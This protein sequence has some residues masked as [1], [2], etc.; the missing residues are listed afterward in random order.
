MLT[1]TWTKLPK[2]S[3]VLDTFGLSQHVK[4]PTHIQGHTLDLVIS[5]DVDILSIY[6]KD[7]AIS[8]HF[9]VF[10]ELQIIPKVPTTSVSIKKSF[11]NENISTISLR[12]PYL[13]HQ[14]QMQ[15]QLMNF[16]I[17]SR[18][19]SQMSWMLLPILRLRQP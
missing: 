5:K 17:I 4:G 13:C 8:D 3:A 10:F 15:R 11:T 14:L 6:I 16:W 7:L 9:C 12:R 19:K 1:I 18:G 2:N